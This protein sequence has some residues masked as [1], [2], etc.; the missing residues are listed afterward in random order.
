MLKKGSALI[1]AFLEGPIPGEV[2]GALVLLLPGKRVLSQ[3]APRV[4]IDGKHSRYNS[5]EVTL[6]VPERERSRE[7]SEFYK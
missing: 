3:N 2:G 1:S 6:L 4:W 5:D 7:I